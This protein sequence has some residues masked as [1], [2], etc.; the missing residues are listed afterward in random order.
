MFK[1]P[2]FARLLLAAL[3]LM[4]ACEQHKP[5]VVTSSPASMQ[6]LEGTWLASHE[7]NRGDTL[8]Y[9]P[10]TYKFP[11]T[12]GRTGFAI[13]PF[14][15]FEQFDI[16]PTDGL[17]GHPGTWTADGDTR[18]RIHLTEGQMPDYTLEIISLD[19]K[20]LKLRRVK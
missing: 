18:L 1:S 4:A 2:S 16:A 10:N 15:R 19:K 6:Q 12:R 14:G 13:E 9:R 3:L 8:V 11:P 20:V 17:A 7:E 5:A